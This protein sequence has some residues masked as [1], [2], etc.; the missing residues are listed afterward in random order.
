MT[1]STTEDMELLLKEENIQTLTHIFTPLIQ[2]AVDATGITQ[3]VNELVQARDEL[4]AARGAIEE[5]K[6][7]YITA[8]EAKKMGQDIGAEIRN[9][10]SKS[11]DKHL[12]E[13][14]E[15]D[16]RRNQ[17]FDQRIGEINALVL[18]QGQELATLSATSK[19]QFEQ[20]E[21]RLSKVENDIKTGVAAVARNTRTLS[22]AVGQWITESRQQKEK[23]DLE[24]TKH[25]NTIVQFDKEIRENRDET[26]NLRA[27]VDGLRGDLATQ[28]HPLRD[29]VNDVTARLSNQEAWRGMAERNL[30]YVGWVAENV[31]W[32]F[33]ERTGN[34]VLAILVALIA[35]FQIYYGVMSYQLN[36]RYNELISIIAALQSAVQ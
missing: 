10:L 14:K 25:G 32:L 17:A 24:L 6:A 15:E 23:I 3:A 7:K 21:T 16:T 20:I 28:V 9:P 27:D 2:Q 22:R 31:R 12:A 29:K 35:G 36:Q 4:A 13:L 8:E 34:I 19:Q 1:D 33:K 18:T 30:V 5:I 26:S 11:I